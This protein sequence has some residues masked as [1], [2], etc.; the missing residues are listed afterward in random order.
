MNTVW[1]KLDKSSKLVLDVGCGKGA[2]M[3]FIKKHMKFKA[4]G[5]DIFPPYL[6]I[7]KQDG[8]YEDVILGDVR[9]LPLKDR[10]FD[11]VI[12]IEVL[13]HLEKEDGEKLL[14]ELE[15]VARKQILITTP[16]SKYEQDAYD[17]NPYQEHKYIWKLQEL[18]ERGY[19]VRGA[20]L[21]G[22]RREETNLTLLGILR[23]CIYT[24]GGVFSYGIPSIGCHAVGEKLMTI[25]REGK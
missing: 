16:I 19:R 14:S 10:Q 4:V 12:C 2:P 5:V 18:R 22:L 3:T 20:G 1:R 6:R 21:K 24:L 8:T 15:R 7:S 9:C 17:E 13:E 25:D 23:H 11:T